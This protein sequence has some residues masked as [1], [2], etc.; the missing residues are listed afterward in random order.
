MDIVTSATFDL[1]PELRD[2]QSILWHLGL[3]AR[4]SNKQSFKLLQ[5]SLH[6]L[7]QKARD[8]ARFSD[9]EKTFLRVIY[10]CPWWGG[11][12]HGLNE[13]KQFIAPGQDKPPQ[14]D[15]AVTPIAD[16]VQLTLAQLAKH[17]VAGGGRYYPLHLNVYRNAL[18][19]KDVV[20]GLKGYIGEL[21]TYNKPATLVCTSD[22][23]FLQSGYAKKIEAKRKGSEVMGFIFKDGTLMLDQ[24]DPR[25]IT[26][27][28]RFRITAMTTA[29]GSHLLTRWRIEGT[30]RFEN[31]D[32]GEAETGLPLNDAQV[33]VVPSCLGVHLVELGIAK[34]FDYFVDW[35]ERYKLLE[36]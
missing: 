29:M 23:G 33:L 24:K 22:A 27:G 3:V 2:A 34:P 10:T 13:A 19:V 30:Y 11:K 15:L 32:Q 31:F 7:S 4:D 28:N 20:A 26:L 25:L 21:Y 14:D 9:D 8:N 16:N 12:E 6:H 36:V 1:P 35:T 17:Y 5:E 18:I